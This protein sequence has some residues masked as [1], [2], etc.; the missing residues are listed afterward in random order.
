MRKILSEQP[1][2]RKH[3]EILIFGLG[4]TVFFVGLGFYFYSSLSQSNHMLLS[5]NN[6]IKRTMENIRSDQV[7]QT[8]L[9]KKEGFP[10]IHVY[11]EMVKPV[12]KKVQD[13]W[14]E[15]AAKNNE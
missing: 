7:E 6:Q 9:A 5:E 4:L 8:R 14:R 11:K 15:K 13:A 10:A 1:L 2:L 3:I 12:P